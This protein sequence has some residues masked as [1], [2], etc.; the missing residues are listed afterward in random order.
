[1]DPF[2]LQYTLAQLSKVL[3]GRG[4]KGWGNLIQGKVKLTTTKKFYDENIWF[5]FF[6]LNLHG[7]WH[8]V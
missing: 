8:S 4:E 2:L 6:G 7:H 5:W 3:G 1:M